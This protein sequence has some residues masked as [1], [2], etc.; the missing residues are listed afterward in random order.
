ML[1]QM[2]LDVFLIEDSKQMMQNQHMDVN[3]TLPDLQDE[4]AK[5]AKI[6][7]E[8][9]TVSTY[10]V[11]TSRIVLDILAICTGSAPPRFARNYEEM[12]GWRRISC[13][14]STKMVFWTRGKYVGRPRTNS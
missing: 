10:A 6:L 14:T 3:G 5:S 7:W 2:L 11:F 8:T 13:N 4:F 12:A 1:T 9:G